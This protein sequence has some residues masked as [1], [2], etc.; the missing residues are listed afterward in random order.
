MTK[1]KL[2]RLIEVRD[3]LIELR[4]CF[5]FNPNQPRD[6]KGRFTSSGGGKAADSGIDWKKSNVDAWHD[7]F[8]SSKKGERKNVRVARIRE[9]AKAIDEKSKEADK[10]FFSGQM[11]KDEYRKH[12]EKANEHYET[13]ARAYDSELYNPYGARGKNAVQSVSIHPSALG[14]D[15][16]VGEGKDAPKHDEAQIHLFENEMKNG[17]QAVYSRM[18]TAMAKKIGPISSVQMVSNDHPSL[19]LPDGSEAMSHYDPKDNSILISSRCHTPEQARFAT[20]MAT[21]NHVYSKAPQSVRNHLSQVFMDKIGGSELKTD[22]F[23]AN[24]PYFESRSFWSKFQGA[25][26]LKGGESTGDPDLSQAGRNMAAIA[27]ATITNPDKKVLIKVMSD[28]EH[29]RT[30]LQSLRPFNMV[31]KRGDK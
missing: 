24:H 30:L 31:M 29:R 4:Q 18:G 8:R 28:P 23:G 27:F 26:P 20:S 17:A 13:L 14:T 15:K 1:T 22:A 21:L 6:A 11:S 12:S 16:M 5:K 19:K 10:A 2:Q 25:L 7:I 9:A 3:C